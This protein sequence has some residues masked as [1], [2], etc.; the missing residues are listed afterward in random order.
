[1]SR[2]GASVWLNMVSA[3]LAFVIVVNVVNYALHKTSQ[4]IAARAPC[5]ETAM[6]RALATYNQATVVKQ[7]AERINRGLGYVH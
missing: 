2:Y 4:A 3:A 7:I 1:V 5:A 6:Q